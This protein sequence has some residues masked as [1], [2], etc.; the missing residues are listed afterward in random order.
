MHLNVQSCIETLL[1]E[2]GPG[3]NS[4]TAYDTSWLARLGELDLSIGDQ[5]LQWLIE[6]QLS[7]GTWGDGNLFYYHDRLICTMSA[8]IALAQRGQSPYVKT[9]WKRGIAALDDLIQRE[10]THNITNPQAMTVGFEM[11]LPK[12]LAEAEC[13]KIIP[14]RDIRGLEWLNHLRAAKINKLKGRKINRYVTLAHSAEML[15]S[16]NELDLLDID[17][18]Q[19]ENGSIGYSPAATAFFTLNVQPANTRAMEYSRSVIKNGGAPD[20]SSWDIFERAWVLW[21]LSLVLPQMDIQTINL[22]QPH[23]THLA[24]AWQPEHGV[25]F[26]IH[27]F[28]KDGDDTSIVFDVLSRFGQPVDLAG[29]LSFEEEKHFRCYALEGHASASANI[30]VLSALRQAGLANTHPSI[31]KIIRFLRQE[32]ISEAFWFDK[33]HT[34]PYYTTSHAIITCAG[35]ADDIIQKTVQWIL[36]TQNLDGSWGYYMP[37][38]EETAYCIQALVFAKR[39]G[40]PVPTDVLKRAK[41]WLEDHSSLIYPRLWIAKCLYCPELIVRSTIMSALLLL[42]DII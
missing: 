4:N 11:I 20:L 5:A 13:L 14:K 33:W 29:V 41:I 25:G 16:P 10:D 35:Y 9:Q 2:M 42:D 21:N 1:V 6:H 19:E 18:L 3:H 40:F 7:D 26:S 12:L 32:Q 36:D 28:P 39:H 31:Q 23:L 22:C 15:L 27:Y 37:T 24:K 34:S 17:N 38:A 8:V 30:H